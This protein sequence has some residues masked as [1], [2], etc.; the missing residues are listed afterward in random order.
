[1]S[2]AWGLFDL[3]G[4]SYCMIFVVESRGETLESCNLFFFNF[5]FKS[6]NWDMA[7]C[8]FNT[9]KLQILVQLD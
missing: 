4:S 3:M 9:C 6:F 8:P 2:H 7:Y 5:F 1:M